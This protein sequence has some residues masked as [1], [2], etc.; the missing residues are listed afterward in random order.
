MI[1]YT[2][3]K[4]QKEFSEVARMSCDDESMDLDR[5]QE[6]VEEKNVY[7][8]SDHRELFLAQYGE[9]ENYK[10]S[11]YCGG[12]TELTA[13]VEVADNQV[14]SMRQPTEE[15]TK[16]VDGWHG[17]CLEFAKNEITEKPLYI[18][19]RSKWYETTF[20]K[21]EKLINVPAATIEQTI[22]GEPIDTGRI[23]NY[24]QIGNFKLKKAKK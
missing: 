5:I 16:I 8:W 7:L 2:F 9:Y 18:Q 24:F 19:I 1:L 14:I 11:R 23:Y 15:E 4:K 3:F 20:E 12:Y 10:T 6:L 21:A 13:V 17:K 22:N